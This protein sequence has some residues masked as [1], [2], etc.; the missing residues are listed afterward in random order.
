M[1]IISE[2][3]P[4]SDEIRKNI[5]R[6][7]KRQRAQASPNEDTKLLDS[8]QNYLAVAQI[9]PVTIDLVLHE[10]AL[11]IYRTFSFR[12]ITIG[13]KSE[14][15]GRYRYVEFF[16]I[17]K[18][19]EAALR[20]LSYSLE[21]FFSQ[22]DYPAIRLSKTTELCIVEENP[23]LPMEKHT[24]NQSTFLSRPR[25]SPEEFVEGDYMDISM[26][27]PED[28]LIGWLEVSK[29]MF[30]RMPSIQTI[31]RLELFAYVLSILI[32]KTLLEEKC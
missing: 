29:P 5:E 13:L 30:N 20:E 3:S 15:D 8:I 14:A 1:G 17:S 7:I 10:A 32:Q 25:G 12:E 21:E 4:I 24:Y 27:N 18:T 26:Y 23:L 11:A 9:P 28:E 6:A 19:A 22:K 2:V 31:K 16:G